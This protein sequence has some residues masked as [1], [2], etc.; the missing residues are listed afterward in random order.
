M[1]EL[2]LSQGL[3]QSITVEGRSY[4][5]RPS[6]RNV[7]FCHDLFHD[8][9]LSDVEKVEIALERLI[10]GRYPVAL[11]KKIALF[12][13]VT[14]QFLDFSVGPKG[15][16]GPRA[17]DFLQDA[18]YIYAAFRQAYGLDLLGRD[19]DLHW[20][21]F[22]S[23]VASLPDNTR[24]MEI[25]SIRTRPIPKPAKGNQEQRRE[26]M[27]LKALYRLKISEEERQ[28]T[29]QKSLEKLAKYMFSNE[30]KKGG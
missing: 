20:W 23:L 15:D 2:D 7:L 4:M 10:D 25:V 3:P 17:M 8:P 27:K 30:P 18:P 6:F 13:A 22:V 16:P 12:Q 28:A 14:T 26:L 9:V 24:M 1:A 21:A 19:C 29:Y 11:R 5:L